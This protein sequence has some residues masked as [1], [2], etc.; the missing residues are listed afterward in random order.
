MA[1]SSERPT[2]KPGKAVPSSFHTHS[3][4]RVALPQGCLGR[5]R[6]PLLQ[7]GYYFTGSNADQLEHHSREACG[8]IVTRSRIDSSPTEGY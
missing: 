1:V 6:A 8:K 5:T 4:C 2:K 3:R 7:D